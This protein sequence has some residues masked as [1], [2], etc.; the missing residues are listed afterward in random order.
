MKMTKATLNDVA[1]HARSSRRASLR[2]TALALGLT[3]AL[4]A[5]IDRA[6]AVCTPPAPPP[7]GI[8]GQTIN[9]TGNTNNQQGGG[10]G[11]G[12]LSDDNNT[13]NIGT[14]A[15]PNATVTGTNFG[16]ET[17]TGGTFNNFGII[18][19][20][21]AAGITGGGFTVNNKA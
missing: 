19:G 10:V 5:A 8:T 20:T 13:Y 12:T 21:N 16:F 2:A 14:S 6:E 17:G 7:T 15:I 1:S 9:C 18:T 11:Y 4:F 3:I